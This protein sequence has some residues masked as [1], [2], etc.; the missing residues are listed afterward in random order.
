[1]AQAVTKLNELSVDS[2]IIVP[3][4]PWL[5]LGSITGRVRPHK[6]REYT[7]LNPAGKKFSRGFPAETTDIRAAKGKARHGE[8][9][10]LQRP[11]SQM[12][13]GRHIISRP[14]RGISLRSGIGGS[15]DGKRTLRGILFFQTVVGSANH[16][17]AVHIMCLPMR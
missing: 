3:K 2:L 10:Q 16:L 15:G 9:L 1:R 17:H 12:L 8:S 4:T 5:S 7:E 11:Y 13:P 14:D 6:W